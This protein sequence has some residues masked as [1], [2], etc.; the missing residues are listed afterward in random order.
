MKALSRDVDERYQDAAEM[1]RDLERVLRER[2]PPTSVELSRFMEVLFEDAERSEVTGTLPAAD[3]EAPAAAEVHED[4]GG[5]A[6]ADAASEAPAPPSRAPM[7]IQ[8][9]LKRFG[10]K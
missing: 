1:Y 7:S 6:E 5:P 10:I 3:V 2:Q 4:F 8:K 9:L